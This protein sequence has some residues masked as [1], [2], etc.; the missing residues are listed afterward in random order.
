MDEMTEIY[1]FTGQ[2]TS[3]KRLC[4]IMLTCYNEKVFLD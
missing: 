4:F 1:S 3:K 2:M